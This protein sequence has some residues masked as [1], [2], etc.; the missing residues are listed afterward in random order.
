[1]KK[2]SFQP[3]AFALLFTLLVPMG[4]AKTRVACVGDSI[5]FG[6][7]IQD[8]EKQSY[9]AQLGKLLGDKYDVR[10]FGVNGHT[11]LKKGNAPYW[12]HAAYKKSQAFE[13]NIVI[14]K[15]GTND[16]K[17]MNWPDHKGDFESN[18]RE[19]IASYQALASKPRIIVCLPVPVVK[20]GNITEKIVRKEVAPRLRKAALATGVELVDL[21]PSL[22]EHP[23]FFPDGLHP[24][25]RGA[26]RMAEVLHEVLTFEH[27]ADFAFEPPGKT[28]KGVYHGFTEYNFQHD[29]LRCRVAAPKRTAKGAPWIWRAYYWGHQPQFEIA[30][31]ERGWHVAWYDVSNLFGSPKAVARWNTFYDFMQQQGFD[32]KPVLEGMSRGGPIIHNWAVA[33]PKKAG[34]IIADNAVLDLRSWPGDFK[35]PDQAHAPL[36]EKVIEVYGFADDAAARAYDKYPIDTVDQLKAA[37][38]PLLYLVCGDDP[39]VPG[40]DNGYKAIK[41]LG[42]YAQLIDKPGLGHHPHSLRDPKPIVE[43]VQKTRAKQ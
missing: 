1:M 15:L 8:R 27:D 18:A 14:I 2:T 28:S 24:D 16:S 9:P 34:G 23:E 37:G 6:A 17:P 38:I 29:G 3:I 33:N 21:H 30:M 35:K 13:P 31:L 39:V 43:F 22:V 25:H 20:D 36:W 19:L 4:H 40:K 42:D 26:G 5:T 12:N 7:R 32:A 41:K 10:N 11:L